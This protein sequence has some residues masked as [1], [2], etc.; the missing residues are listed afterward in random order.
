MLISNLNPD[1]LDGD[2]FL[3][4]MVSNN[5]EFN[6]RARPGAFRPTKEEGRLLSTWDGSNRKSEL[7][8][9]AKQHGEKQIKK[10]GRDLFGVMAVTVA[11]CNSLKLPVFVDKNDAEH[12]FIDLSTFKGMDKAK[13]IRNGTIVLLTGLANDRGF[14]YKPEPS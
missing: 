11:E 5:Y 13:A 2:K 14:L 7:P 3:L 9:L 6:N 10:F 12:I 8:K 1:S 4:R